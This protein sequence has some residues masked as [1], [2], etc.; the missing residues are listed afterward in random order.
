MFL[1]DHKSHTKAPWR[2][3]SAKQKYIGKGHASL[4][5]SLSLCEESLPYMTN[6]GAE[7]VYKSLHYMWASGNLILMHTLCLTAIP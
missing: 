1:F 5:E 2:P 6:Y 3:H 7:S 4:C